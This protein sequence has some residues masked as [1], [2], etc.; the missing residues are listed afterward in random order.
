MAKDQQYA[1]SVGAEAAAY[2]AG[3]PGYPD[4]AVE[5]LLSRAATDD[6][7]R[8][9]VVDVGAG[10]GKFTASLVARSAS[11]TAVEPDELMRA[12]LAANLPTVVAVEGTGEQLPLG[13]ASADVVTYAQSW[14]WVDV[15][16]ASQEAARVLRPG[17]V[18][19]L[20]W[21][22]R[23]EQVDW[24]RRLTEV[25]GASIAD[26]YETVAPPVAEP[27][28]RD[29]HAEFRWTNELDRAAL[30]SLVSS[31]SSVIALDEPARAELLAGLDE[32][33]DTHPDLA[34]L[35]RYPMP[36][37]TRVTIARPI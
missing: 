13:D 31:R 33:L 24:V 10:T 17:G 2:D 28:R 35:D 29:A 27:L 1:Q 20:V 15:E 12:R 11:V 25:I 18:L 8:P 6:D 14:H 4:D 3:R 26:E 9:D 34:G 5:W 37:L 22:V 32:L 21:N 16:A 7:A 30:H 36:Y 19:A 23:D